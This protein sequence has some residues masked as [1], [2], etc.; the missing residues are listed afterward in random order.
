MRLPR[1]A[2][3]LTVLRLDAVREA[4]LV[5]QRAGRPTRALFGRLASQW[6]WNS[7]LFALGLRA[8]SM[9]VWRVGLRAY[10]SASS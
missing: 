10:P 4:G 2:A 8:A 1:Q 9:L 5:R 3:P 6:L 7:T